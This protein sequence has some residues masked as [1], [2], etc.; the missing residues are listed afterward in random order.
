VRNLC[1]SHQV[2]T[3]SDSTSFDVHCATPRTGW[4]CCNSAGISARSNV[5]ERSGKMLVTRSFF[6]ISRNH[7]CDGTKKYTD[8]NETAPTR[9]R[10]K[11]RYHPTRIPQKGRMDAEGF[12]LKCRI[13]RSSGLNPTLDTALSPPHSDRNTMR[14]WKSTRGNNRYRDSNS[15]DNVG[16]D[17]HRHEFGRQ[18][19]LN[20]SWR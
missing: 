16:R 9:I 17:Q 15:A 18:H 4:R 7:R 14:L 6:R 3:L 10:T 20:L 2:Q 12:P 13:S 8:G 19:R 5:G 11:S 1:A